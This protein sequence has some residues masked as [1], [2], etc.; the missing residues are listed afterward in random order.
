MVG[1][2]ECLKS[3]IQSFEHVFVV[4]SLMLLWGCSS[5]SAFQ[6]SA[7]AGPECKSNVT[8]A[9]GTNHTSSASCY[10]ETPCVT[11]TQCVAVP[12][13]GCNTKTGKC[14][15]VRCVAEGGFCSI[16]GHCKDGLRC[17]KGTCISDPTPHCYLADEGACMEGGDMTNWMQEC[18]SDGGEAVAS[19]PASPSGVCRYLDD[20]GNSATIYI[21]KSS[22]ISEL[23]MTCMFLENGV[24]SSS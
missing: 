14:Q 6:C 18:K 4:T 19:C 7:D 3:R 16:D 1:G 12:G 24:Y 15:I 23:R 17:N 9:G 10:T 2:R 22:L 11:D 13:A 20:S 21:Y 5:G 8:G